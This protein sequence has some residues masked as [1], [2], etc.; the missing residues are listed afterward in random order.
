MTNP[1]HSAATGTEIH[2][3][4][5]YVQTSDPGSVGAG[6]NWLDTTTATSPILKRRNGANNAWVVV[7]TPSVLTTKGDILVFDGSNYV[8]LAIG[9]DG[10]VLSADSGQA[11]GVRW[12]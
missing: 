8:R 9:A 6:K 2:D 12:L 4:V 11:N 3:F 10:T 1:L 7:A 5:Q